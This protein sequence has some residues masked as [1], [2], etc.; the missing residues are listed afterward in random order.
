MH[1]GAIRTCSIASIEVVM[2]PASLHSGLDDVVKRT[3]LKMFKEGKI[4]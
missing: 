1:S 2:N 4:A 3:I